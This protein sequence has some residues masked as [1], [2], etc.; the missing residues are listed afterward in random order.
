MVSLQNDALGQTLKKLLQAKSGNLDI[1]TEF[2]ETNENRSFQLLSNKYSYI[3][4]KMNDRDPQIES[5]EKHNKKTLGYELL[6]SL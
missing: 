2:V 4:V 3:Q 6:V 5:S 1:K